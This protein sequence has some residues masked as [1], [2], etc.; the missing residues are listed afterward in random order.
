MQGGFPNVVGCRLLFAV[1]GIQFCLRYS[2]IRARGLT[3]EDKDMD[4]KQKDWHCLL[5]DSASSV[6]LYRGG[7][8]LTLANDRALLCLCFAILNIID[9][10]LWRYISEI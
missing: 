2:H 6:V 7:Y 4:A 8:F 9:R 10:A 3:F 1:A 5:C